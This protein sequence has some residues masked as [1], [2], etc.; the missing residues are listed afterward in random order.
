M[1]RV[2]DAADDALVVADDIA[3]GECRVGR[4]GAECALDVGDAVE[5]LARRHHV[6]EVLG[7]DLGAG[8]I[9]F[10][11]HRRRPRGRQPK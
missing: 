6:G 4:A 3:F 1:V 8:V 10:A 9:G 7:V 5:L 2:A 11:D